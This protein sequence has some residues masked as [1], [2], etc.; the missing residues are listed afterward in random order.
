MKIHEVFPTVVVQDTIDNHE[1]FKSLYFE[2][3]KSQ[4]FN[5][6]ENETP[7]NSGRCS[8][9]LNED[10][11]P[12]FK[13]LIKCVRNYLDVLEIDHQKLNI[14]VT[15]AWVGYHNKDIPQLKPHIH[16]GADISF[17]YYISSDESSDKLCVHNKDNMNELS[18]GMFE[19]S[20]RFNLI[21]K[22]NKYN[23][24]SYT[25][26]PHEGTVVLFPSSLMH[27]TLKR[28]NLGDRYVIAGDIKLCLKEY[29]NLH[30]QSVPH[31]SKWLSF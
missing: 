4:W 24:E 22:F 6:Y 5:G 2:E 13:S 18:K 29:Y 11:F 19:T 12:F 27:S 23:C 1:K 3:L 28:D 20:D 9:Q 30:H 21:K 10:Y 16:N 8:L 31:P 14:N 7:E 26:T 25:I 15:K 17:C